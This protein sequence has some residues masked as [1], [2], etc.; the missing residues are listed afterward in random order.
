ML[1]RNNFIQ[2]NFK[3]YKEFITF[4]NV[5]IFSH[6]NIF[7]LIRLS[8]KYLYGKKQNGIQNFY[9]YIG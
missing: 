8:N 2:K 7:T 3:L 6:F 1:K 9:H 4:L 5:N